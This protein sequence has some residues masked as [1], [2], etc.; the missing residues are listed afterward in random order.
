MGTALG[1][2]RDILG[3]G[4]PMQLGTWKHWHERRPP[5]IRCDPEKELKFMRTK[6][7]YVWVVVTPEASEA[8]HGIT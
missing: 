3:P 1:A 2:P 8:A 6:R 4:L 7:V 5:G